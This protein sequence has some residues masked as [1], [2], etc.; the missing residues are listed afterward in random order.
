MQS[1]VEAP[2]SRL[3]LWEY[4]EHVIVAVCEDV[5]RR[6][7][8]VKWAETNVH[9]GNE[10]CKMAVIPYLHGIAHKLKKIEQKAEVGAVMSAP[11]KLAILCRDTCP[12]EKQKL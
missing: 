1:A 5:R 8:A 6:K 4:P 7:Q 10:R 12:A 2:V 3:R 11:L 9:G